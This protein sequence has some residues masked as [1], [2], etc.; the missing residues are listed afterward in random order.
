MKL[1]FVSIDPERDSPKEI[2]KFIKAFNKKM[3][4]VT[5]YGEN[6]IELTEMMKK[7]KVFKKKKMV[8]RGGK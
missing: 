3:I 7:F 2:K 4:G 6:N 8:K 5:G 1:V